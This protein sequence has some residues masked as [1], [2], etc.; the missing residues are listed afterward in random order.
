M[1]RNKFGRQCHDAMA[2]LDGIP[3]HVG[4]LEFIHVPILA[5]HTTV[6][7]LIPDVL[8]AD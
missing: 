5:D 6:A 1:F 2:G 4:C 7:D 8:Q 3:R